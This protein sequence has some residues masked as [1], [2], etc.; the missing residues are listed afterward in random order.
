MRWEAA[1]RERI[2]T[3]FPLPEMKSLNKPFSQELQY[4]FFF[5]KV[6]HGNLVLQ[7]CIR[8]QP[9]LELPKPAL[10]WG[11]ACEQQRWMS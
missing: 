4:I 9:H 8:L 2:K 11:P 3:L 5:L 7:N 1:A 10:P 6:L